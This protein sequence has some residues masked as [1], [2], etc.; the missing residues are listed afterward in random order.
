MNCETYVEPE[1]KVVTFETE[2]VLSTSTE[3]IQPSLG[4]DD[5][6]IL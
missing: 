2:D 6:E 1:I 5:T 3:P 4:P